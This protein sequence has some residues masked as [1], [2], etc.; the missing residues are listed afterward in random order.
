MDKNLKSFWAN[1]SVL[2]TGTSLA[3]ALPIAITPILTRL[4]TPS[5]F[6][7]FGIYLS[8]LVI[9][10]TIATGKFELAIM[11]PEKDEAAETIFVLGF[12]ICTIFSIIC[13]I[14]I[15]TFHEKILNALNARAL[16]NWLYVLPIS[17]FLSGTYSLLNYYNTRKAFYNDMFERPVF[18]FVLFLRQTLKRARLA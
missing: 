1:V 7:V 3:Q 13:L 17:I 10:G 18:V 9:L 16:G 14:I 6:G 12:V 2:L 5:D 11:L 8:A 15:I 4:Y